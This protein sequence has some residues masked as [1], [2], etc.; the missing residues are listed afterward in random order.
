MYNGST[1]KH[2]RTLTTQFQSTDVEMFSVCF[3]PLS[4][5]C[6]WGLLGSL[7]PLSYFY[8][9]KVGAI[10]S[11]SDDIIGLVFVTFETISMMT[12]YG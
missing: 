11:I 10:I 4:M 5:K 6:D 2:R 9:E 3:P 8:P 12:E 7:V 1:S